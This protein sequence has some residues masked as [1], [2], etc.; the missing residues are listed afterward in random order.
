MHSSDTAILYFEDVRVPQSNLIG[1]E[2]KGFIYQMLQFQEERLFAV[3]QGIVVI[4]KDIT[5]NMCLHWFTTLV[6]YTC[7]VAFN[8]DNRNTT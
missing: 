8:N 4:V 3:A 6:V 2:G 5:K 7:T 1:D